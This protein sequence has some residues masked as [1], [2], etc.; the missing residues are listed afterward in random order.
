MCNNFNFDSY[1]GQRD[2]LW[3]YSSIHMYIMKHFGFITYLLI[4]CALGTILYENDNVVWRART[5]EFPARQYNHDAVC[6]VMT[7]TRAS[8]NVS[9]ICMLIEGGHYVDH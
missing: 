5:S 7:Q 6:D 1:P 8:K 4:T 2:Q 9:L 3:Y